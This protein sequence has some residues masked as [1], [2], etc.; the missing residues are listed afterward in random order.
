MRKMDP[1]KEHDAETG[2]EK[3][4]WSNESGDPSLRT[5]S[6]TGGDYFVYLMNVVNVVV[7]E[8]SRT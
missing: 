7:D 4:V 6:P 5:E 2:I 1:F 8:R 3:L